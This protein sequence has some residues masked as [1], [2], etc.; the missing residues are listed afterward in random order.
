MI[1]RGL[2]RLIRFVKRK[3]TLEKS[4]V[5]FYVLSRL[6]GYG[7]IIKHQGSVTHPPY[8]VLGRRYYG[9]NTV[10]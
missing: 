1:R 6:D 3:G 8:R 9:R 5:P 2:S 10:N 4:R 7:D